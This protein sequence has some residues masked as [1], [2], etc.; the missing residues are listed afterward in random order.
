MLARISGNPAIT[1]SEL[2]K[3]LAMDQTT[4][5]RNLQVLEKSGYIRIESEPADQ[6]IKR[7]QLT[8]TG[9]LKMSEAK[10]LWDKAQMEMERVLGRESIETL[11]R[12]FKKVAA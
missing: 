2:A 4:V 8:E 10:P 7:I 11:L 5:S 6:R 3:L 9:M 12:I 1:V